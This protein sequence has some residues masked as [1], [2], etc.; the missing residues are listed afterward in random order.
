MAVFEV[1]CE[2]TLT[3]ATVAAAL[4]ALRGDTGQRIRIREIHISQ[5]TA[6]TSPNGVGLCRS[7]VL[8]TGALTSVTPVVR[9]PGDTVTS[10]LAVTA[11][12]TLAPTNGG[13]GTVFRRFLSGTAVGN[14]TVWAF[15][16]LDPLIMA[17]GDT[18][19]GELCLV[20]LYATTP[21]IWDVTWV[22]EV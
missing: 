11:W 1:S 20:N 19:T 8:G 12:A 9:D 22:A 15:D 3:T 10:A 4:C 6:G 13:I 5:K 17:E 16:K 21:P 14:G 7:T 18:A 2:T